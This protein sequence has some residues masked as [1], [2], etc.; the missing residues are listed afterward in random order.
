M[1]PRRAGRREL[2]ERLLLEDHE[3]SDRSIAK[4]A[5]CSHTLVANVRRAL[6]EAGSVSARSGRQA[7]ATQAGHGN[8]R[9]QEAGESSPALQHGAHSET[10]LPALR[11]RFRDEL[12][13]KYPDADPMLVEVQAGRLA[14]WRV[15]TDFFDQADLAGL[16]H[17]D[18]R[19]REAAL[20]IT[21]LEA[22]IERSHLKLTEVAGG[23]VV[24]PAAALRAHIA[25]HYGNGGG[26]GG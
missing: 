16:I 23:G 22:A 10:T 14:R 21:R 6:V 2:V 7:V 3:R 26:A 20:L 4:L 5:D 12:R 17:R 1:S 8:L 18:G 24:D 11:Q 13:A 19:P 15:L 25:E 9:R